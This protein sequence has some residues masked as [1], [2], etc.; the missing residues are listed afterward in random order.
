[1]VAEKLA[2]AKLAG[3]VKTGPVGMS[4]LGSSSC[5]DAYV[6]PMRSQEVI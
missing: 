2:A 6:D 4:G 1:M 5:A 3:A